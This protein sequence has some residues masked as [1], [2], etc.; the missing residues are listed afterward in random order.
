MSKIKKTDYTKSWQAFRGTRTLYY[1]TTSSNIKWYF[2]LE[3]VWHFIKK[4]YIHISYAQPFYS[5]LFPK[6]R[7]DICSYKDLY[8]SVHRDSVC[9]CQ[10]LEITQISINRRM[11][12][13]TV[14]HPY[15]G[16]I[17]AIKKNLINAT[18]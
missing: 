14:V 10:E 11:G 15:S 2:I 4:L 9:N 3:T 7:E 8:A 18:T 13:Q 16:K 12:K 1:H 6:T 5:Y 17:S